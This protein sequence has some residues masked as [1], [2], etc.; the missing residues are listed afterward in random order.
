MQQTSTHKR[1]NTRCQKL[2]VWLEDICKI[3]FSLMGIVIL[4]TACGKSS[5]VPDMNTHVPPENISQPDSI[6]HQTPEKESK[7]VSVITNSRKQS[8]QKKKSAHLNLE[9]IKQTDSIITV[10]LKLKNSHKKNISAVRSFLGFNPDI[11]L[12]QSITL[13]PENPFSVAAP[14]EN[15]FDPKSGIVKIGISASEG[16]IFSGEEVTL[17]I[18]EFKRTDPGF[19]SLDFYGFGDGEK[20]VVLEKIDNNTF[21]DILI[22]PKV[23]SLLLAPQQ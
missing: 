22:E 12:G 7:L 15:T 4:L 20:T 3:T 1:R 9:L 16:N 8:V 23:P 6:S 18:I 19:T 13:P 2:T 5:E 17:A 10:A 11:L 21:R 14:G